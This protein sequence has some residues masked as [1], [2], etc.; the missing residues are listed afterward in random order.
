MWQYGPSLQWAE[1]AL[2]AAVVLQVKAD[3]EG[4]PLGSVTYSQ[5][6][7]FLTGGG[8]W[9]ESRGAIADMLDLHADDISRMGRQW[10][11]RRQQDALPPGAGPPAPQP[12]PTAPSPPPIPSSPQPPPASPPAVRCP[13]ELPRPLQPRKWRNGCGVNPFSPFR[14][15]M[16]LRQ[17]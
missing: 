16:T 10:I 11:A 14:H 4:E 3:I 1:R 8:A 12:V 15:S 6:V 2:W 9:R 7:E 17:T 5:A 13:V